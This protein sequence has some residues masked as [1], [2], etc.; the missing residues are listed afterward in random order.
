M[1]FIVAV[2]QIPIAR[3]HQ[4]MGGALKGKLVLLSYER[5]LRER[6]ARVG[7]Y[8]FVDH[9]RLTSYE[10]DCTAVFCRTL[11]E[12]E[13]RARILNDPINVL[14]RVALLRSLQRAGINDFAVT[15]LGDGAVPEKFPVFIRSR[16]EHRG[17]ESDLIRDR[18]NFFET[19][20]EA[21]RNGLPLM[22]RVAVG[23]AAE[24]DPD[25]W[26][27]KYGVIRCGDRLIPQH[28]MRGK[29]W[30]VKSRVRD[31]DAEA[32]REELAFVQSNPHRST[33]LEVFNIAGVEF[34]RVDY[35][36]WKGRLQVYEINTNPHFPRFE[37]RDQRREMRELIR[38]ELLGAFDRINAEDLPD[39]TISF[40]R[41]S[42]L[43]QIAV[44]IE[45]GS[46]LVLPRE[47]KR[48]R[49]WEAVGYAR[50]VLIAFLARSWLRPVKRI[51]VR[52][53]RR[54]FAWPRGS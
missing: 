38:E 13:P 20:A 17:P 24:R 45:D 39:K 4:S 12:R 1:I 43:P 10:L 37:K 47:G 54:P 48:E 11:R 50:R 16:D 31:A 21:R 46:Y 30:M 7:H 2:R 33:L 35:G 36:I 32:A 41:A 49:G 15:C 9:D 51:V 34:G 53:R 6:T 40:N 3:L 29:H 42:K 18:E 27:R 28:L 14:D 23:F 5:L 19:I 26:F 8:I 44:Q 22:H 25:G 52:L